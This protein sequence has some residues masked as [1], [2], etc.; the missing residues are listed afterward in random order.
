MDNGTHKQACIHGH[1]IC[2][3]GT[4]GFVW[5]Q[6]LDTTLKETNAWPGSYRL[7]GAGVLGAIVG[8]ALGAGVAA[9]Q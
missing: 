9:Q 5:L 6:P 8:I 2:L 3:L 4:R 7:V 1:R